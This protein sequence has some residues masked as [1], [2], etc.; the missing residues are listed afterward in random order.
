MTF[1]DLTEFSDLFRVNIFLPGTMP[2]HIL[3]MKWITVGRFQDFSA[4]KFTIN[5]PQIVVIKEIIDHLHTD[6]IR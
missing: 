1:I 6:G 3:N 5:D 2:E 4:V